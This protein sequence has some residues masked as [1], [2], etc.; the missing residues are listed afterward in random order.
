ME[1]G[2][3]AEG[4]GVTLGSTDRLYRVMH[5]S[6]GKMFVAPVYVSP[7]HRERRWMM[8]LG[9]LTAAV[10]VQA[11]SLRSGARPP[12]SANALVT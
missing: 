9:T 1:N 12:Q 10:P 3:V 11:H 7:A 8:W 5:G 2:Y 6:T 4:K